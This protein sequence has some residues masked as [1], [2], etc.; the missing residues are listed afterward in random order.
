M[1]TLRTQES[2]RLFKSSPTGPEELG[3]FPAELIREGIFV[4]SE[5]R[6][7]SMDSKGRK[8]GRKRQ[9]E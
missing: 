4:S 2:V 1:A 7:I 8:K 3:S 6:V 5:Y 9:R